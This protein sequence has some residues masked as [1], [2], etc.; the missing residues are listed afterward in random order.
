MASLCEAMELKS[1]LVLGETESSGHAWLEVR[2]GS[3]DGSEAVIERLSR[4]FGEKAEVVHREKYAWLQMSPAGSLNK[5][6]A[7]HFIGTDGKL[8]RAP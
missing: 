1:R 7:T 4:E 6:T 8:T 3:S 2:I 5:Y